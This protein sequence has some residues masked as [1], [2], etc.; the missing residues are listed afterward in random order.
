[1]IMGKPVVRVDMAPPARC[2]AATSTGAQRLGNTNS[3]LTAL[4]LLRGAHQ[5]NITLRDYRSTSLQIDGHW[6]LKVI[7]D[8]KRKD[9]GL[10]IYG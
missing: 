7:N 2:S 3:R 1:M 8:H 10:R 4:Q 5:I 6:T 9:F